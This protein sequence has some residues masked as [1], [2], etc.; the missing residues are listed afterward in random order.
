MKKVVKSVL[1][2]IGAASILVFA[3]FDTGTII[4]PVDVK[5]TTGEIISLSDGENVDVLKETPDGFI[6]Q[7]DNVNAEV[8]HKDI[9][10]FKGDTSEYTVRRLTPL[11]D[12]KNGGEAKRVLMEGEAVTVQLNEG[13]YSFVL[14][15]DNKTG[16]VLSSDLAKEVVENVV[17]AV[18]T[19]PYQLIDGTTFKSGT[20]VVIKNY[21]NGKFT[22]LEKG[23]VEFMIDKEYVKINYDELNR[24]IESRN[25][26]LQNDI[27]N[28]AMSK[29]GTPY[30]YG[31]SGP[32]SFDCSGFTSYVYKELG[33]KIP[34][35]SAS[36]SGYGKTVSKEE[37][38]PGDLV[39]FNTYGSGVSHVG[40]Y[41][42]EGKFIHAA[43]TNE[44]RVMINSLS[45]NYYKSRYITAKRVF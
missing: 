34:R 8:N 37:L 23:G 25:T 28:I 7:K 31:T 2:V 40:I 9:L 36:Q 45:E 26:A 6:V 5:T 30:A 19:G 15:E 24:G 13:E 33:I 35:S 32:N 3:T 38:L 21:Q 27:L 1:K 22:V 39:F 11:L 16:Y 4:N 18:I 43:S 41:I 44:M 20:P 14:T 29:L 17:N 10:I 12:N 42:G